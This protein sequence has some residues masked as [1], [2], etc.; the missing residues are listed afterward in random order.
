M[1]VEEEIARSRHGKRHFALLQLSFPGLERLLKTLPQPEDERWIDQLERTI[2]E[3]L[4]SFDLLVRTDSET[5]N[6][7]IPDPDGDAA[8]LLVRL[9]QRAHQVLQ[10]LTPEGQAL[11]VA[12]GYATYPTDGETAE[13][14]EERAAATA[15]HA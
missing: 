15:K 4:R 1:R 6:A 5:F 13:A 9:T 2:A 12:T 11:R 7:L 14:L 10:T 8:T 3:D